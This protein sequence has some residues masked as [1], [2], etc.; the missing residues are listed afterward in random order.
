MRGAARAKKLADLAAD[1]KSKDWAIKKSKD[2]LKWIKEGDVG[3]KAL[4]TTAEYAK[5][6]EQKGGLDFVVNES[7]D[8]ML[9]PEKR[10]SF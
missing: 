4:K 1:E 3:K 9:D 2:T 8:V 5:W 10:R 6:V 7:K